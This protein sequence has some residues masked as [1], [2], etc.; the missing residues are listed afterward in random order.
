MNAD[1]TPAEAGTELTFSEFQQLIP[2]LGIYALA[3]RR[4]LPAVQDAY[5]QVAQIRFH[6]PSL[7]AIYQDMVAGMQLPKI[8]KQVRTKRL[9]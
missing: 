1:Q 3:L 4:I 9:E 6:Q 5:S 7:Q 2:L 8:V